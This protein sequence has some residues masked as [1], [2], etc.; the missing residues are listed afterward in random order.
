MQIKRPTPAQTLV[1]V[2]LANLALGFFALRAFEAQMI[3]LDYFS[4][5]AKLRILRL[6]LQILLVANLGLL[7][8][9]FTPVRARML[10]VAAALPRGLARLKGVNLLLFGALVVGFPWFVFSANGLYVE[11]FWARFWVFWLC[12]LAGAAL[13]H[14]ARPSLPPL[15]AFLI[16]AV[17]LATA[18]RA[19][20]FLPEIST[21]PLSLGWSEVSR[22]YQASLYASERLYGMDLP[23]SITHPSRYML[24][25]LP[26]LLPGLPLWAHRAWQV[27]LWW[28]LTGLAAWGLARRLQLQSRGTHVLIA[29]WAF[30]YLMQGAIFYNLLV[31]IIILLW[32]FD[33]RRYGRSLVV[34]LLASAWAGF[35]RVNWTVVPGLL[36]ACLYYLEVPVNERRFLPWPYFWRA[37]AFFVA[38]IVAAFSAY[39]GYI[40]LSG[41]QDVR[42]FGSAFTSDLLWN[43]LLPSPSF[44]LGIL[45]GILIV[46][47]PLVAL[48][49]WGVRRQRAAWHPIRLLGLAAVGLALFVSGLVVSVK[50][51]GGTNLHNMDA[52]MLLVMIAG[53]YVLFGRNAAEPDAAVSAPI[54]PGGLLALAVMIPVA[55]AV[56]TGGQWP[57]RDHSAAQAAIADIDTRLARE[58]RPRDE[59]LLISQRQLLIFDMLETDFA[60]VPEYEQIFLMEMAISSNQAYLNQFYTDLHEQRFRFILS[61]RLFK[62]EKSEDAD[63]LAEENNAWLHNV[64]E[65]VLCAYY[66]EKTY[67]GINVQVLM[68][69]AQMVC[70]VFNPRPDN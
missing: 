60:L 8:L 33:S 51:G 30:L 54:W 24:Q 14:A 56:R 41:N 12:A 62:R 17:A 40:A 26:F 1:V 15:D 57:E 58:L 63:S 4:V 6:I 67:S 53:V 5:S 69:R 3:A 2:L 10:A 34:V 22:Y 38:G 25:G 16:A 37:F 20:V 27:F 59:V 39:F 19:A 48:A 42:Q 55:L 28:S 23:L 65:P 66:I 46:L 13:L 49:V 64:V 61:D 44:P 36:A 35:S 50:I 18:H 45:P 7:A 9:A 47:A 43:R 68:P 70:D 21:Y 52:S 32:G 29:A 11:A 31:A